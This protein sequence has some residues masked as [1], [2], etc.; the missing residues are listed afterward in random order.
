MRQKEQR[1][2]TG[3]SKGKKQKKEDRQ[4][5]KK[6][7]I[8]PDWAKRRAKNIEKRKQRNRQPKDD[9]SFRPNFDEIDA[10]KMD[11]DGPVG[12]IERDLTP[13]E[14]TR[15]EL[16]GVVSK[17]SGKL[18]ELKQKVVNVGTNYE[19]RNV[20]ALDKWAKDNGLSKGEARNVL[21]NACSSGS[22][23]EGTLERVSI[24]QGKNL[25]Q[26]LALAEKLLES[27]S[28]TL[29][30]PA[31]ESYFGL[32]GGTEQTQVSAESLMRKADAGRKRE[33]HLA[34]EISAEK[35]KLVRNISSLCEREGSE[36]LHFNL[37][38]KIRDMLGVES[39]DAEKIAEIVS[40]VVRNFPGQDERATR[41]ELDLLESKD[42]KDQLKIL[43]DMNRAIA[44]MRDRGSITRLSDIYPECLGDFGYKPPTRRRG[45]FDW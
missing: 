45:L 42:E 10:A 1:G 29:N 24:F 34:R 12:R 21:A 15:K 13:D 5:K 6:P 9:I 39:W 32:S 41:L 33:K 16:H 14:E 2:G 20:N 27:V 19:Q 23:I 35:V 37:E 40:K 7:N 44:Q 28:L 8:P 25:G 43:K 31:R 22:D 18:I 38:R 4:S 36:S 17:L 30:P 26:K 11:S 3:K